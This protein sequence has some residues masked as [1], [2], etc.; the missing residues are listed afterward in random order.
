MGHTLNKEAQTAY[1]EH[2][3]FVPGP[4]SVP[5]FL[6]NSSKG[7]SKEAIEDRRRHPKPFPKVPPTDRVT[8]HQ[9]QLG[10]H[11]TPQQPQPQPQLG[12]ARHT[13]AG[14]SRSRSWERT[15]HHSSRSR[16]RSRKGCDHLPRQKVYRNN[17]V[18]KSATRLTT[19]VTRPK[20]K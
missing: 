19:G 13:T 3:H 6:F 18:T 2:T 17:A 14:R 12:S 4:A 1:D 15:A 10:P 11:G 9:P 8:P 16:S 5:S 7:M 20:K